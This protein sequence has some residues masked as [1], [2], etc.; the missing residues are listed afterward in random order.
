MRGWDKELAY[1]WTNNV[2]PSRPSCSEIYVYT[3]YLRKL[4]TENKTKRLSLLVLGSTPEFRDWGFEEILDV[5]VVDKSENYYNTISREIRH[6][7]IKETLYVT[8]WEDMHFEKT[9]DIIVGDLSLGNIEPSRFKDF[10]HNVNDALAEGGLFLGKSFLWREEEFAK[11][12]KQIIDD[13]IRMSN[14]HP[15]TFINH[16]LALY[17]L[18]KK[19]HTIDFS[20]M[21]C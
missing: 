16:Q 18:D 19:E 7:N 10:I 14:L 21:Y 17:C 5:F 6:K 3:K 4:Q 15:Y 12:P 20:K 2:A 11:T 8:N 9:F 1:I 13:Y